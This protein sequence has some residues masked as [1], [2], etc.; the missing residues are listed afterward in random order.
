MELYSFGVLE[1]RSLTHGVSRVVL[2]EPPAEKLFL[3]LPFSGGCT[4]KFLGYWYQ[5]PNLYLCLHMT[6]SHVFASPC[7]L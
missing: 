4:R 7:Y 5:S 3:A 1:A 2:L 6:F